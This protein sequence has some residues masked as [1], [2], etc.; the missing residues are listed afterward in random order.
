MSKLFYTV[1]FLM[2]FT[3]IGLALVACKT[4]YF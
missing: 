3:V 1:F 4:A 2:L